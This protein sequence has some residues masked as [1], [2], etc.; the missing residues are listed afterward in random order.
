MS[1][2]L[3]K[4]NTAV[5]AYDERWQAHFRQEVARLS[6]VL[7]PL[8][9]RPRIAHVG[10]TAIPGLQS[11]PIVDVMIGFERAEQIHEGMRLLQA[12]GAEYIKSANATVLFAVSGNPRQF[13]YHLV[14]YGSSPWWRLI[15]IRD[16]L[17]THPGVAEEYGRLKATLAAKYANDR[18]LYTMSKRPFLRVL[19]RRANAEARD[20]RRAAAIAMSHHDSNARTFGFTI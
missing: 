4:G 14:L 16:Y 1:I 8:Q 6:Q 10:S 17:R 19:I 3:D 5:V 12:T 18:L 9:P 7:G 2:G 11:K 13:H 15:H 20:N